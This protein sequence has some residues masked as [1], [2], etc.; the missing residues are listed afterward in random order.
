MGRTNGQYLLRATRVL[1][2]N[3]G[4]LLGWFL[5]AKMQHRY[6]GA[7]GVYLFCL[8]PCFQATEIARTP[9]D[10]HYNTLSAS[11]G[12]LRGQ[13]Q[14][15]REQL[16]YTKRWSCLESPCHSLDPSALWREDVS[17]NTDLTLMGLSVLMN[18]FWS[19]LTH[20]AP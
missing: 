20:T 16:G 4:E 5:M 7:Y 15:T 18:S 10:H 8:P 9:Y 14:S 11:P 17:L 1:D 2:F 13:K 3:W 12:S 19:C 6:V